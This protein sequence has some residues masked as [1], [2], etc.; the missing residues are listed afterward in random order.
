[1]LL[2]RDPEIRFSSRVDNYSRFRP[3][4]PPQ[5]IS[6]LDRECGLSSSSSVVADLGSGTGILT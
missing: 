4:Y 6:L 1:V 2:S 5:I 3:G